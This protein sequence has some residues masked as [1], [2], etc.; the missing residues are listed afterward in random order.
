MHHSSLKLQSLFTALICSDE[1]SF[2]KCLNR[3][4][5]TWNLL[6]STSLFNRVTR[7][8][9]L[10]P[11]YPFS[12]CLGSFISSTALYWQKAFKNGPA[13]I[14]LGFTLTKEFS[15]HHKG[16]PVPKWTKTLFLFNV[17]KSFNAKR[18]LE[19]GGDKFLVLIGKLATMPNDTKKQKNGT[20]GNWIKNP[21]TPICQIR[22]CCAICQF[23]DERFFTPK[24]NDSS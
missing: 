9:S 7:A 12:K 5:V 20:S 4:L 24:G 6:L 19:N 8:A 10:C 13:S 2:K 16:K 17:Y 23:W 21:L 14:Y 3:M 11:F 22:L 18:M 15:K 1:T